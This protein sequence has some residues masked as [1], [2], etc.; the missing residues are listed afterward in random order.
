MAKDSNAGNDTVLV[1]GMGDIQKPLNLLMAIEEIQHMAAME[2][3]MEEPLNKNFFA[4][5]QKIDFAMVGLRH[6]ILNGLMSALLT[7]LAFGVVDGIIPVF[8]DAR[9]TTFD[10]IYA[11]LLAVAFPLGFAIFLSTLKNCYV[12]TI[13]KSMIN[14]LFGGLFVG[15]F[16]KMLFVFFA[17]NW[18]YIKL[19]PEFVYSVLL[20]VHKVLPN[21]NL[22]PVYYWILKFKNVL[23]E[24]IVFVILTSL[25]V[26]I[27][28]SLVLLI[29]TLKNRRKG[30][31][32]IDEEI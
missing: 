6:G 13:S 4:L 25:L 20:Q 18:L 21:A 27:I 1:A 24:S 17:F 10:E 26:I 14:N 31:K 16:L 22:V 19:T 8:G 3:D 30:A 12:G 11:F 28:P 32:E 7:P 2:V 29:T 23:P 9:L 15:I 5:K